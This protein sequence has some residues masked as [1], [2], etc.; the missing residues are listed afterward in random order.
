MY[1]NNTTDNYNNTP[2]T[3]NKPYIQKNTGYS[4]FDLLQKFNIKVSNTNNLILNFQYSE[5]SIIPRFDRLNELNNGELKFAEWYYGPQKRLLF[6]PQYQFHPNLKWLNSGTI[7]LA[8]QNVKE[9]RVKR[10]YGNLERSHQN[11]NV[12][13]FSVNTDFK[14]NLREKRNLFY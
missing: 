14:V 12:D 5:S 2:V 3:N 6:S 10:R 4:Q 11:E 1:S 7:T 8:Y 13:V 9:S